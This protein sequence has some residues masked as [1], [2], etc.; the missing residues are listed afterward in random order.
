MKKSL[1]RSQKYAHMDMTGRYMLSAIH[2]RQRDVARA[3]GGYYRVDAIRVHRTCS[4]YSLPC[5]HSP[6]P[7]NGLDGGVTRKNV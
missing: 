2:G 5:F 6:T 4:Q 7:V 1:K 3:H